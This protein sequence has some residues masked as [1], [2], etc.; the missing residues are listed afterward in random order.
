VK[1]VYPTRPCPICEAKTR[2]VLFNQRFEPIPGLMLTDGYDVVVCGECGFVFADKIPPKEVFDRY[3]SEAS[4]YE[5][6]HQGGQQHAAEVE[7]LAKLAKWIAG[8]VPTTARLVDAGCATGELLVQLR[9]QGFTQLT[10][11]DPSHACVE[12]ARSRHGLRVIQGVLGRHEVDELPFEALILSA[13]LEHIP[14]LLPFVQQLESWLLPQGLLVVEVPDAERFSN[15]VNAPFQEFSVEHVNFFSSASLTNLMGK[16]GF[17][18]LATRQ[19]AVSAGAGLVGCV[20][21]MLFQR[22]GQSSVPTRETVSEHGIRAYLS[23]CQE[24]MDHEQQLISELVESQEPVLIWGT[25]TLCQRLLATTRLSQANISAFIDSNPHYQGKVL[26]GRRI[27]APAELTD[28][29]EPVLIS[30][31]TFFEEIRAQIRQD[32]KLN[33]KII[34][35]HGSENA[36]R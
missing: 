15:T 9:R 7:R 27:I 34:R 8:K 1:T 25:G 22:V 3:Y 36:G 26:A 28:Y 29:R 18:H 13:V 30:S 4:K 35:I 20:L 32:L 11:L 10:G 12:F 23:A 24:W 16:S 33:N 14:D 19:E 31:W 6:S 17:I 2:E 21:T 5:F